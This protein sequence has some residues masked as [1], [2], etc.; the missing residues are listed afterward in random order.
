MTGAYKLNLETGELVEEVAPENPAPRVNN[1]GCLGEPHQ[2]T[3]GGF[4][5]NGECECGMYKHHVHCAT[6]GGVTQI[7]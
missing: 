1:F 7:G 2:S 4:P 5:A 6:C 3:F